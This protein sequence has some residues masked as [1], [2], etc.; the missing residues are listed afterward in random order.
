MEALKNQ[1][2]ISLADIRSVSTR[3]LL[4]RMNEKEGQILNSIKA[5]KKYIA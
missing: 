5:L 2:K 4:S 3:T 1:K